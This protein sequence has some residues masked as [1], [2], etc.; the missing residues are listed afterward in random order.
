MVS[1]NAS[2]CKEDKLLYPDYHLIRYVKSGFRP[3]QI[4]EIQ[5]INIQ[6][7]FLFNLVIYL[8]D[9]FHLAIL[10]FQNVQ[11]RGRIVQVLLMSF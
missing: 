2:L 5:S 8:T 7:C 3:A 4:K 11:A 10:N 9:K 1:P 6:F